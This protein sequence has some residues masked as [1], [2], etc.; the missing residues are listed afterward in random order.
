[1][2]VRELSSKCGAGGP[3]NGL[4]HLDGRRL[5]QRGEAHKVIPP[6]APWT[7]KSRCPCC[8]NVSCPSEENRVRC[9]GDSMA[10]SVRRDLGR[11]AVQTD[12]I[13][14]K[15]GWTGPEDRVEEHHCNDADIGGSSRRGHIAELNRLLGGRLHH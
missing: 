3:A 10:M 11:W 9:P 5:H 14:Q 12:V 1:V 7:R 6:T 8:A 2:C 15:A 4:R 13:Q